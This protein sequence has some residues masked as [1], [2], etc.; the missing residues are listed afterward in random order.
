MAPIHATVQQ[1]NII[2]RGGERKK[3]MKN[4]KKNIVQ[5]APSIDLY[6]VKQFR[7]GEEWKEGA[8]IKFLNNNNYNKHKKNKV[9]N[10]RTM[11]QVLHGNFNKFI[12]NGMNPNDFNEKLE[13]YYSHLNDGDLEN[14]RNDYAKFYND[15]LEESRAKYKAIRDKYEKK[16]KER[17]ERNEIREQRERNISRLEEKIYENL[18][19]KKGVTHAKIQRRINMIYTILQKAGY[20][21]VDNYINSS[22]D[23]EIVF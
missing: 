7:K 4:S 11:S 3:H 8:F 23:K 6:P 10:E 21:S 14:L 2:L 1:T 22:S 9:Y 19:M 5:G 13:K 20:S 12:K 16:K 18:E 15:K 17:Q